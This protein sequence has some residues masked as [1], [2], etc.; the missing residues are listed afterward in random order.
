[1]LPRPT[2]RTSLGQDTG[3]KWEIIT[4]VI[5]TDSRY[6]SL[7]LVTGLFDLE[8]MTTLY[9]ADVDMPS[10]LT[11]VKVGMATVLMGVSVLTTLVD[12]GRPD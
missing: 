3:P 1:M 4:R 12:T 6:P 2:V 7:S 5:N 11:M 10:V 8:P 9:T